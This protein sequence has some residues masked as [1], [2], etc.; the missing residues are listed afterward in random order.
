MASRLQTD[1]CPKRA[2]ALAEHKLSS[3][4]LPVFIFHARFHI[5]VGG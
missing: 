1:E 4:L 3:S 2:H 5:Q